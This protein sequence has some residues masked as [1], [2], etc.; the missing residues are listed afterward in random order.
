M[1]KRGLSSAR[2]LYTFPNV[3]TGEDWALVDTVGSTAAAPIV[4]LCVPL[5]HARTVVALINDAHRHLAAAL[6]AYLADDPAWRGHISRVACATDEL[7][8][9]AGRPP[10]PRGMTAAERQAE[11]FHRTGSLAKTARKFKVKEQTVIRNVDRAAKPDNG[12]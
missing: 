1:S 8:R 7:K 5:R 6:E 3:T 9:I 2:I 4:Q 11:Y 12:Q 10:L